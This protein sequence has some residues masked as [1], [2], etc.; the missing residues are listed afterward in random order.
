MARLRKLGK[1]GNYFALFYDPNRRP[2]EKSY[3]L[4]TTRKEVAVKR[5]ARALDDY[6]HGRLDPWNPTVTQERLTLQEAADRFL[7]SRASLRLKTIKAYASALR[8]L[9]RALPPGLML[10]DVTPEHLRPLIQ[11]SSVKPA[12]RRYR[13]RHMN[14]FF[15]WVVR[16][17][18]IQAS[19][20]AAL[21]PPKQG[22]RV[23]EYLTPDQLDR[24]L[25]CIDADIEL[26]RVEGQ[27]RP[28]EVRWLKDLILL[29]VGTG[30]RIG[31]LVALRWN[32]VDL[33]HAF[34]TVR[35]TDEF[36][37]KSGH[38]RR[39]PLVGE[40]LTVLQRLH[41]ER[42]DTWNGYVLTGMNGGR[43]NPEYASKRFK[44]YVRLARLPEY[45]RFHSLR[46][47]CASW[48]VMQ[49]VPLSVV[50]AT[51]G[52][53]STQVTEKYS[54]LAPD[55]LVAAMQSTFGNA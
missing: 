15:T 25:R 49:G 5:F 7:E 17:G 26:K 44:Y 10:I 54:H 38:E 28:G 51:L 13:Y 2:K 40:A 21:R 4:K 30:M 1:S 12:T 50:Q 18:W 32:A 53:S 23:P 31:E 52:H 34:L 55:V 19:P 29:A 46:H 24:L 33:D 42:K 41:T 37:T 6:E 27:I 47:T 39:L 14:V 20:M 3:P 9:T 22:E 35:N 48:L 43:L 45:I 8:T 36:T 11:E 16:Q